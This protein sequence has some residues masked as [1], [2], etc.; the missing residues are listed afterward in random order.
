[1]TQVFIVGF[2]K[3]GKKA[4][5]QWVRRREQAQV[6]IIDSRPEALTALG[7]GPLPG[8]RIL[9]D[10]PQFLSDYQQWIKDED[11]VIPALPVHLAWKWLDL[12]IETRRRYRTVLPPRS[13]GFGLPF[14]R[15]DRKGLYLSYADFLCPDNCPAPIRSCFITKEKRAV[16][17]WKFI[18]NQRCPKGTLEV[19]E[20]RQ[21][22]PGVGGYA[23]KE[24]RRIRDLAKT[25]RPPFFVAT[26]CRCHGVIHGLTW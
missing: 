9:A 22:G 25:A 16:P 2:G 3:F 24:L 1:L 11:W 20:S 14:S 18:S 8:I 26:A 4:L 7:T 15:T 21:L 17:L 23:F 6:W 19:I 10:G 5:T 13:L 12:N